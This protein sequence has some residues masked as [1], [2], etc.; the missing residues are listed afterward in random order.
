MKKR[1]LVSIMLLMLAIAGLVLIVSSRNS[2]AA[3]ITPT[4]DQYMELRLQSTQIV[5]DAGTQ[6]ILELW[7][8]N[9][10]FKGLDVRFS[11]DSTKVNPS[12]ITTNIATTQTDCFEFEN[13]FDGFLDIF[14]VPETQNNVLRYVISLNPIMGV[15]GNA[16]YESTNSYLKNDETNGD[17]ISST[18]G[19]LIGKISFVLTE[20][21]ELNDSIFALVESETDSPTT[22]IKIAKTS[23]DYYVDQSTFRFTMITT[24]TLEGSILTPPTETTTNKKVAS[25]KVYNTADVTID[26]ESA[27]EEL[28][29]GSNTDNVNE[30]LKQLTA[31]YEGTTND[32]GTYSIELQEGNYV[33][34]IDKSGYL[35]AIYTNVEIIKNTTKTMEEISLVPG[36]AD[37]NGV[38][39]N[40]DVVKM[41]QTNGI[42]TGEDGYL[43]NCDLDE[44]GVID[45]IDLILVYQNNGTKRNI[46]DCTGEG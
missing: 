33:V 3:E 27:A 42:V 12:N 40:S 18:N 7:S 14:Q 2:Y 9:L 24:G 8:Y 25:I 30:L 34:L 32:D 38:V 15:D 5:E 21:E 16:T 6:V 37:K 45:N 43:E 28:E 1:N 29:Q 39:N 10:D 41:Y 11:Y 4:S 44:S 35:D 13:G 31:V 22:G 23:E 26:W 36:D 20:G 46:I 19:V 17:Y